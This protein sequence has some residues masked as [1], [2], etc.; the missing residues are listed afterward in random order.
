[1]SRIARTI[2]ISADRTTV[3]ATIANL[4]SVSKWNPNVE[5]ATCV[6]GAPGVGTYRRC[7]LSDGGTIDEVVSE[8]EEGTRL[9]LAIGSHGGVRS[10]DMGFD[11]VTGRGGTR[12][13]ALADYHLAFGPLGPVIDRLAV[14]HQMTRM[15][16]AALAGL[17][18]TIEQEPPTT[19]TTKEKMT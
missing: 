8:W 3:W 15:L 9:R 2:E 16:D 17:K 14:K 11:L 13:T 12:V 4:E 1:M 18:D 19:T 10:A 7:R 5:T 6:T